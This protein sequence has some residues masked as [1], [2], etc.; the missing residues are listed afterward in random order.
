[1]TKVN[2]S[3]WNVEFVGDYFQLIST[4]IADDEE[5]AVEFATDLL[6]KY[7]GFDM[8]SISNEISSYEVAQ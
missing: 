4:V 8:E 1:M 6:K 3:V 5:Q 7:Y 2:E